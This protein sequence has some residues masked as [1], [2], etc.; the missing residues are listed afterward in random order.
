MK[1]GLEGYRTDTTARCEKEIII[2]DGMR[3]FRKELE[4]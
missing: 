4:M 2:M 3:N 1:L